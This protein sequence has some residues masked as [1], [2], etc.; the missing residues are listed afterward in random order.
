MTDAIGFRFPK[1]EHIK[2]SAEVRKVFQH[3]RRRACDG[4]RLVV[5]PN[6]QQRNRFA[7][8]PVRAFG[9]AVRRNKAKRVCREIFRLNKRLLLPGNDMVVVVYPGSYSYKQRE[10]QMMQLWRAAGVLASGE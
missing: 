3:G 4:M 2:S 6:G 9:D 5:L 8:A 1:S 7:C 10:N